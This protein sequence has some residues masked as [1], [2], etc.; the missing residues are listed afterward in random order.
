[1]IIKKNNDYAK[2]IQEARTIA[3]MWSKLNVRPIVLTRHEESIR[4]QTAQKLL[5]LKPRRA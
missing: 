4:I 1:M 2:V 5:T 3:K